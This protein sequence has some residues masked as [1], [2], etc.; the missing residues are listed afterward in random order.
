MMMMSNF[1]NDL[2]ESNKTIAFISSWLLNE[3][4]LN[5]IDVR[6][7]STSCLHP[8]DIIIYQDEK[9]Y[10]EVKEDAMSMKTNNVFL[11]HSA[12]K[13]YSETC[14]KENAIPFLCIVPYVKPIPLLFILCD[15]LRLE[16]QLG[17]KEGIVKTVSGGDH[18]GLGYIINIDE[19]RNFACCL[20]TSI[21]K[22]SQIQDFKDKFIQER[23]NSD[24][25]FFMRYAN[26][27]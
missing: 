8:P 22:D 6:E 20:T 7:P 14:S 10:V 4:L 1:E 2:K 15:E 18:G 12:L 25:H 3:G 13:K 16:L 5:S 9:I 17:I 11:E 27:Q 26:F 19:I 23:F 24:N 21:F